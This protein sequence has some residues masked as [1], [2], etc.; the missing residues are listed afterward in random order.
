MESGLIAS[1]LG[2]SRLALAAGTSR[3]VDLAVYGGTPSGCM[4]ALAAAR[5]GLEVVL[6]EPS[7]RIGGMAT[8]G[9][10]L[11]DVGRRTVIGGLTREY[12]Q[13][14]ERYYGSPKWDLEPHFALATFHA[15][16][17]E[18][19]V[20]VQHNKALRETGGVSKS[21]T[22]IHALQFV[23]G[24]TLKARY[25]IDA[26]Y[27]GDL[28]AQAGVRHHIGRESASE[29]NES[30]AGVRLYTEK[31][32]VH[33]NP[34]DSDGKLLPEISPNPLPPLGS[35]DKRLMAYNFRLCLTN[36]PKNRVAF[37]RPPGYD[38]H[39]YA[40]LARLLQ[41]S[42]HPN[43]NSVLKVSPI[44]N[45]K[46]DLNN[47]GF[48]STDYIGG[49]SSAYPTASYRDR[50]HLWQQHYNYQAGLLY[51]LA[52]D[53]GIPDS[54]RAQIADLGLAKDEFTESDNWPTQLYVREARRMEGVYTMTQADVTTHLDKIDPI[55]MGSYQADSHDM[56]RIVLAPNVLVVEGGMFEHVEPYS[57]PYRSILPKPEDAT[58]L[59]VPVCLSVSHVAF[60]TIRM[61][62]QWMI[63]GEAAGVAV[64]QAIHQKAPLHYLDTKSLT[65]ALHKNGAVLKASD[66]A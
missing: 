40:L 15:L 37:P 36:D 26:S 41:S 59:L 35:G 29:F 44:P 63:L 65:A 56:Q 34:Y 43:L 19:K 54:V 9:L 23:D 60:C 21:G 30:W 64:A 5:A 55:G 18:A 10:G 13:V 24:T 31:H 50:A 11:T 28:L 46:F 1:V 8:G 14:S 6:L 17:R 45:N 7:A 27:E 51:F 53:S 2:G 49:G 32:Y 3:P 38:P 39:R 48:F 22:E 66:I 42:T 12:Y 20:T 61:E 25:F 16:L 52:N 33:L 58:N 4:A 47:Q 62:P 57:I